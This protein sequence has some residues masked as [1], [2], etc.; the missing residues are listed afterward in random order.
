MLFTSISKSLLKFTQLKTFIVEFVLWT[1]K[2]NTSSSW[3][4]DEV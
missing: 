1:K 4:V 2:G 3:F